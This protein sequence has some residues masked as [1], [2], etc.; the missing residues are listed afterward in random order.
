ML[1]GILTQVVGT[2]VPSKI[3]EAHRSSHFLV[4]N[5]LIDIHWVCSNYPDAVSQKIPVKEKKSGNKAE[6]VINVCI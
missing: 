1:A 4:N 5:F 3:Q 2:L 6:T